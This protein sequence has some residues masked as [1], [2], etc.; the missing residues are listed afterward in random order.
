MQMTDGR[1]YKRHNCYWEPSPYGWNR[2]Y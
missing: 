2:V 1:V